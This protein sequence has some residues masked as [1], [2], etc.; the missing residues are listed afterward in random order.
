VIAGEAKNREAITKVLTFFTSIYKEGYV[1]TDALT[2]TDGD[3]N[4]NFHN[5]TTVMTPNPSISIP[6]ALF[7]TNKDAYYNKI[8]TILQPAS[9]WTGRDT[10]SRGGEADHH[11]ERSNGRSWEVPQYVLTPSASPST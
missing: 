4:A 8:G 7:F 2:W 9:R 5:K 1:P 11:P 10:L 6:G 3:N